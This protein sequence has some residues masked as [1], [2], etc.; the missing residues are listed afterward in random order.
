MK[1]AAKAMVFVGVMAAA[2][3]AAIT[4]SSPNSDL[5]V[6][7]LDPERAKKG[8]P[9]MCPWRE[10]EKDMQAFFPGATGYTTGLAVFTGRRL[11]VERRL[12]PSYRVETTA[13]NA[14][15]VHRGTVPAGMVVV[16]RSTGPHGA[17]EV[18]VAL[19]EKKRIAG[20]RIQ[21]QREPDS[22]AAALSAKWLRSFDGKDASSAFK[23]GEDIAAVPSEAAPAATAVANAVRACLVE[24]D[25]SQLSARHEHQSN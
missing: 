23:P 19:D 18:V 6:A 24:I 11:N 21:R 10:P 7:D 5:Q 1:P 8:G 17:I 3:A 16:R 15:H 14:Y 22:V 12:G 13:L 2:I 9:A 4:L 25:E 20:V